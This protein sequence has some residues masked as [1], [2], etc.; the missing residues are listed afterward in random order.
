M[1]RYSNLTGNSQAQQQQQRQRKA[2]GTHCW[3]HDSIARWVA[4]SP[5]LPHVQIDRPYTVLTWRGVA[6]RDVA[7]C[8]SGTAAW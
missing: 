1:A 2:C 3:D 4:V 8:E 5:D 6:D 7:A